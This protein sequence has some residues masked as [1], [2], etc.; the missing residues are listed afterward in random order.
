MGDER[1]GDLDRVGRGALPDI[2]RDDPEREA[3]VV[4]DRWVL[5]DP[6]D[7]D[8]VATGGIG[9]QRVAMAGWI[10]D[11]HEAGDRGEQRTGT[12]RSE[13]LTKTGTRTAVHE[14]RNSGNPRILRFSVTTFHSSFV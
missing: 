6:A 2:V 8:L 11:D 3:T 13:W 7:E 12:I 14:M 5:A 4:R 10:V 9:R 1:L